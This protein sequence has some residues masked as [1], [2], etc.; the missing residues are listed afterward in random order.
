MNLKK[1]IKFDIKEKGLR[2][3]NGQVVNEDGI[4]LN[5]VDMLEKAFGAGRLSFLQQPR[6]R[7]TTTWPL[8]INWR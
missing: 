4:V 6:L 1:T 2:I 3:C 5:L 8:P 7:R